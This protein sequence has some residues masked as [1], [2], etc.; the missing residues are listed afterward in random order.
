[1]ALIISSCQVKEIMDNVLETAPETITE[2]K[3]FTAIIEDSTSGDTKTSLDGSGNVLWKQG[4]QV[5]IF[6][7][8]TV[9]EQYQVSDDSD[10]KTAATLNK[11]GG[12][13]FVAGTE[14][15]NNVAFYP[16]ASTASIAKSGGS[17]IISDIELPATQNYAEGSF[18]NGAFP[19]AAVTGTT[20][21]MN[22]KFKNVLGGLKLQLKGTASI[23]SISVTGNNNE[24]LCG[25]AE[26]T[27][28][29]G[30]VPSINLTDASAKTVTL[31]CGTGV[32][33]ST[34]TA[35]FFIIALPP[36]TMTGGFT[37]VVTD[38][39]GKKML[40]KTTNTQT[41]SRSAIL[42]MPAVVYQGVFSGSGHDYVDLGLPSGTLWAT[43]NIGATKPEGYG[44][45]FA[46]GE[47]ESKSS[48]CWSS[49]ILCD[50]SRYSLNKYGTSSLYGI[51]DNISILNTTDDVA[52]STW[53]GSWRTP[54]Q[55]EFKELLSNCTG[56]WTSQK[57]VNGYKLTGPNG[58][59]IFLPASG[60]KDDEYA[61][62]PGTYGHYWSSS[63]SEQNQTCDQARELYIA[64]SLTGVWTTARYTGCTVRPV[65]SGVPN[66]GVKGIALD[67]SSASLAVGETV[68]LEATVSSN[69]GA[70]NND[71]QWS[72][73]NN[74]VATVDYKG[75]IKAKTAGS[76][77][78]TAKTVFGGFEAECAITVSG[79]SS[80]INGH[81]YVDLGLPS[82]LKWATCNVGADEPN[83]TGNYFAWGELIA[84]AKYSWETYKYCNG[85]EDSMT[86]YC[87]NSDLGAVDNKLVL[88]LIDDVAYINWGA[89]WRMPTY[90]EIME[91]KNNCTW[92]WVVDYGSWGTHSSQKGYV[93]TGPNGNSIFFPA[94]G[95][96]IEEGSIYEYEK[97]YYWSS[98]NAGYWSDDAKTMR[99]TSSGCSLS[100]DSR[101]TGITVRPVSD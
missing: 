64:S 28:A 80:V 6:A 70:V 81:E 23:A 90:D 66:A 39:E 45:Y 82:G 73:S 91:L 14:I 10:G 35:T 19:M 55:N 85:T 17:Y 29:N 84:K 88:E 86:K 50:G 32:A 68:K 53:G 62:A 33:L 7:A 30:S 83:N 58:N 16:Y 54:T 24:I 72:S 49:Y 99:F 100:S 44:S 63:L 4:D 34:E 37:V 67:I 79:E 98:T 36:I 101:K 87:S 21:D 75:E 77:I 57:G 89:T 8:S 93:V 38:I 46:W 42:K 18:G 97:G 13:G 76:T 71:V 20:A 27:V 95:Y 9:N 78:I 59:S 52:T 69:P 1:M 94:T 12:S 40:I 51:V 25:D 92:S 11:V 60:C 56:L 43:C 26:V 48:Y 96:C 2:T 47:T 41:I 74:L 61:Y 5:S 22:L 31:D 65:F 15:D 3:V